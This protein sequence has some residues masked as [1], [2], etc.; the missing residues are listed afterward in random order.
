MQAGARSRAQTPPQR[1]APSPEVQRVSKL[2]QV[3]GPSCTDPCWAA[4]LVL[5]LS[6]FIFVAREVEGERD[7]NIRRLLSGWDTMERFCLDE[8]SPLVY[9]CEDS[10]GNTNPS[11]PVCVEECPQKGTEVPCPQGGPEEE[12]TSTSSETRRTQKWLMRST[13]VTQTVTRMQFPRICRADDFLEKTFQVVS[14]PS[15]LAQ[16]LVLNVMPTLSL[17]D[18]I[19]ELHMN[20][21]KALCVCI[22][23]M[24][25]MCIFGHVLDMALIWFA[26]LGI[27]CSGGLLVLEA[28]GSAPDQSFM[29]K[30][31]SNL[32]LPEPYCNTLLTVCGALLAL[33]AMLLAAVVCWSW[34]SLRKAIHARQE[35]FQSVIRMCVLLPMPLLE[36]AVRLANMAL[37]GMV[38][39]WL[40]SSWTVHP[41]SLLGVNGLF[42]SF[43]PSARELLNF[44]L[45]VYVWMLLDEIIASISKFSV[46]FCVLHHR[47]AKDSGRSLLFGAQ[48]LVFGLFRALVFHIGS[49]SFL[50]LIVASLRFI[51]WGMFAVEWLVHYMV[52]KREDGKTNTCACRIFHWVC[53]TLQAIVY[54]WEAF[55]AM[56]NKYLLAHIALT[57]VS[58][59]DASQ[60]TQKL[61]KSEAYFLE[62]IN[63]IFDRVGSFAVA[64]GVHLLTRSW[65]ATITAFVM[66][67][68]MLSAVDQ[69]AAANLYYDLWKESKE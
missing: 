25:G 64:A 66:T 52:G 34:T 38:S 29:L 1:K 32:G 9:W 4:L 63:L 3:A 39:V 42:K 51:R 40:V 19:E 10:F 44:I 11:R 47:V 21:A 7:K 5:L 54:M 61:V 13:T 22:A 37:F 30:T 65:M 8:Q 45:T 24:I 17:Q 53:S 59:A 48:L 69:T 43:Q 14:Q 41:Y 68:T 18:E 33:F 36:S 2:K 27:G 28:A 55:Q 12:W 57:S 50:A 26:I 16:S 15:T 31:L 46:A 6:Y 62:V 58:I 60:V 56:L 35:G 20:A 23:Y 49:I 67:W